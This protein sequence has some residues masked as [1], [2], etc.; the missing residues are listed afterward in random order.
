MGETMNSSIQD[1][2]QSVDPSSWAISVSE[3]ADLRRRLVL[4]ELVA[5]IARR[6]LLPVVSFLVPDCQIL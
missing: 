5:A 6:H 2:H 3:T 4:V 1:R